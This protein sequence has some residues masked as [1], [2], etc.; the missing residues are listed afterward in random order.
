VRIEEIASTAT[1]DDRYRFSARSEN[2]AWRLCVK[3]SLRLFADQLERKAA[4]R[5]LIGGS[6]LLVCDGFG[7]LPREDREFFRFSARMLLEISVVDT[8]K[9]TTVYKKVIIILNRGRRFVILS[10]LLSD[11]WRY[12][13]CYGFSR[14]PVHA[15][16]HTEVVLDA[17]FGRISGETRSE[18][19]L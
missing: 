10:Y 5:R 17:V 11:R 13:S 19:H 3:R 16:L 7:D 9:E 8:Q 15:E 14:I 12:H 1:L 6:L 2:L 4:I 18:H